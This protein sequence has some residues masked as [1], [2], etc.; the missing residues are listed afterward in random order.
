MTDDSPETAVASAPVSAAGVP[1]RLHSEA[2]SLG[3]ILLLSLGLAVLERHGLVP[4]GGCLSSL[5]LLGLSW[6]HRIR[7]GVSV[8]IIPRK[9]GRV[10]PFVF[11][12]VL[13]AV[14]LVSACMP[15]RP[16]PHPGPSP[17]ESF[18]LLLLVPFSE[19]FF[20]RGLL[21]GHLRKGFTAAQA[22]LLCSLL[23]AFLHSPATAMLV[24]GLLSLLTCILVL[25]TRTL[26]C[27]IQLHIAWNAFSEI[28]RVSDLF[29]SSRWGLAIMGSV[30]LTLIAMARSQK[31]EGPASGDAS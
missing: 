21:F 4:G 22:T 16:W 5:V 29:S 26:V 23:F 10:F 28:N 2:I 8:P 6:W 19:E 14:L 20:F 17:V 31:P 3:A 13:A 24:A 12:I 11:A 1:E 18:H 27:A 30:V 9:G 25:R 15:L 7:F